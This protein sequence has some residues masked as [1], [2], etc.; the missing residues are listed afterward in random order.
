MLCSD[1]VGDCKNKWDLGQNVE[2]WPPNIRQVN[3][4]SDCQAGWLIFILSEYFQH[5]NQ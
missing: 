2:T 5:G 4:Y 3:V 1:S